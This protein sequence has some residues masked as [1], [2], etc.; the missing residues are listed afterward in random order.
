MRVF[1]SNGSK[2]WYSHVRND[3]GEYFF[4]PSFGDFIVLDNNGLVVTNILEKTQ[5]CLSRN[6]REN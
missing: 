6:I 2:I 5:K 3:I 4:S 1:E